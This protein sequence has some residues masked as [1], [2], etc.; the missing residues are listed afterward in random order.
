MHYITLVFGSQKNTYVMQNVDWTGRFAVKKYIKCH[1]SL[2]SVL[3]RAETIVCQRVSLHC[4][5]QCEQ[6][7][8]SHCS[9]L[10]IG[11]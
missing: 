9:P 1:N 4:G 10:I 5:E 2:C 3:N 7:L 11:V 8:C 6:L